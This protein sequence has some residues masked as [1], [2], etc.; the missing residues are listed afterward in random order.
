[1][2]TRKNH[3]F[4]R[5]TWA[6]VNLN[7]IEQNV[8]RIKQGLPEGA[9]FMAVVKANAYGHGAVDVAKTAL[10]AGAACLGVAILDEA[11]ALRHAGVEAPILVL[12]YVRPEDAS[13]AAKYNVTLTVFQ[14]EWIEEAAVQISERTGPVKCHVKVDTGMGRI[15]LRTD[16]EWE[17]LA[18]AVEKYSSLFQLE[19]IYTHFATADEIDDAY[20]R[21]QHRKFEHFLTAFKKRTGL[22]NPVVHSANSATAL[23][24]REYAHTL[25]RVGI[26]MY[27]LVPSEEIAGE[28]TV[29]LEQAFS[30]HSRITH[31]KQLNRGEAVSYGATYRASDEGEWIGT[32]PIGY[33]D[34]WI[35]ANASGGEV[36]IN[37]ER[38]PIVGRICMDQMMI[39][40]PEE[41]ARGTRVTLIGQQ[42]KEV[43]SADE[44][45][46]R[47]DTINYEIPCMI[48]YRVPRA[49]YRDGHLIHLHNEVF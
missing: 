33:A 16:G 27:G 36:L 29:P 18:S 9:G 37:G 6:E 14:H 1:M 46:R 8:T 44:V 20:V 4:Y 21:E 30:L 43:I 38:A 40:L 2:R 26:S 25:V 19:G 5:D 32:I 42:G 31:V 41:V 3:A 10:S 28:I 13:L 48:S 39:R 12:G 11:L 23:R 24:Y 7:A 49:I 47:L 15:G 45:A 17:A 35:R 22:G 34:G